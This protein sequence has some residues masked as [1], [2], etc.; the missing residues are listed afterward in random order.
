MLKTAC[1]VLWP[2]SPADLAGVYWI[3]N[4]RAVKRYLWDDKSISV[5]AT[6]SCLEE[7]AR[8]FSEKG[9]GLFGVQ[10]RGTDEELIGI[11]GLRWEEGIGGME[12]MHCLL[13]RWWGR[14]FATEAARACLR[15]AFDEAELKR[16]M[17]GADEPNIASLRVIEKLGMRYVGKILPAAPDVSYFELKRE[18]FDRTILVRDQRSTSGESEKATVMKDQEFRA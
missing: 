1:L 10:L 6:R 11:C 15:Y 13:P 17:V 9:V 5:E 16:V 4:D 18:E 12:I 14:G 8:D 2:L 7:S 3:F